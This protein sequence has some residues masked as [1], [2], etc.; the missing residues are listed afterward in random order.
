MEQYNPSLLTSEVKEQLHSLLAAPHMQQYFLQ[1]TLRLLME[2][3][4]DLENNISRDPA[5][6]KGLNR[7]VLLFINE[8]LGEV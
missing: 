1:I 6:I 2:N 4:V 5:L 7:G 8:L 3:G